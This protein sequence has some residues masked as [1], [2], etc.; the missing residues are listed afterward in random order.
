MKRRRK[1]N[2]DRDLDLKE[3]IKRENDSYTLDYNI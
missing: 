2:L 3:R 1:R